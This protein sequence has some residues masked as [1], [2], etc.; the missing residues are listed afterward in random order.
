MYVNTGQMEVA[1]GTISKAKNPLNTAKSEVNSIKAPSDFSKKAK[2]KSA[3]R[4]FESA[5]KNVRSMELIIDVKIREFIRM[6]KSNNQMSNG[7]TYRDKDILRIL[8]GTSYSAR[9]KYYDKNEIMKRLEDLATTSPYYRAILDEVNNSIKTDKNTNILKVIKKCKEKVDTK[10]KN[11]TYTSVSGKTYNLYLQTSPAPWA[12]DRYGDKNYFWNDACGPTALAIVLSAYNNKITPK[13]VQ[14][15]TNELIL[16]RKIQEQPDGRNASY[17]GNLKEVANSYGL[18]LTAK[19]YEMEYNG[20]T[21]SD[22]RKKDIISVLKKGGAVIEI[23]SP[24]ANN[25]NI[26]DPKKVNYTDV[27]HFIAIL[28]YRTK[29]ENG[30]KV[31]EVY[32]AHGTAGQTTETSKTKKSYGWANIDD[33]LN[34]ESNLSNGG[35]RYLVINPK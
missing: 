4:H 6:E 12:N 25:S 19:T 2:L 11:G 8:F 18:D 32:V 15:R 24:A 23:A 33:V 35:N 16:S 9:N 7:L 20:S 14:E 13:S 26:K 21:V 27:G 28:D 30:K 34:L 10:G 22:S 3:S 17:Y 1:K 29:N 5:I 31:S